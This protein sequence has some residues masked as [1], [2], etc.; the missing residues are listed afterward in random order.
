M[1]I[2]TEM[3]I[4]YKPNKNSSERQLLKQLLDQ[5]VIFEI[6]EQIKN[7][8]IKTRLSTSLKLMDSIIV[9]TAQWINLPLVSSETKFKSASLVDIV[10]LSNRKTQ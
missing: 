2:I 5:L 8:A 4:Q 10:L 3:E 9:A 6:N 7:L 1:S